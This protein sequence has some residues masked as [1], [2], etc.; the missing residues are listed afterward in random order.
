MQIKSYRT[1]FYILP[2][3]KGENI[4]VVWIMQSKRKLWKDIF[5]ME[6]VNMAERMNIVVF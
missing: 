6:V 4:T 1:V 2:K 3:E 5:S